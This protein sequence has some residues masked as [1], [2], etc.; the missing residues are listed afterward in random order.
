[1][2]DAGTADTVCVNN[3]NRITPIEASR[4]NLNKAPDSLKT[5]PNLKVLKSLQAERKDAENYCPN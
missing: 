5:T 4:F 2:P 1:L 3:V